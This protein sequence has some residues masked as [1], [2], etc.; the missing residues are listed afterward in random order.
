MC[1]RD[2]YHASL[3][4]TLAHMGLDPSIVSPEVV[5]ICPRNYT[6]RPTAEVVNVSREL[7][8]LR[9]QLGRRDAI[10][11]LISSLDLEAIAASSDRSE[12]EQA[13]VLVAELPKR[14]VPECIS[15]CDLARVCRSE[16]EAASEPGICLL[17]T[18]PS[19]RDRTRSRMPSS[20]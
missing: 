15:K 8:S 4:D 10:D 13:E 5:L 1:I 12:T 2:S 19:P 18:S 20:A 9:R 14:F 16:A 7:R 3:Q 17:Y 6:I 11:R